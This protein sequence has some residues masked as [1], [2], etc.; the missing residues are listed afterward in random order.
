M[1]LISPE[2][3]ETRGSL[4]HSYLAE[5]GIF[6]ATIETYGI[7]IEA[8]PTSESF[9]DRL[10]FDRLSEGKLAS[11]AKEVI[12]FPCPDIASKTVSWIARPLPSIGD[13]KFLNPKGAAFPFITPET[14]G[15]ASKPHKPII[16]TEGPVKALALVQAGQ[17]AI[18]VSGVWMATRNG[19]DGSVELIAA[20]REF[21]WSGRSVYLAFD[22]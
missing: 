14:W 9:R 2:L 17:L 1:E 10:G 8:G 19:A 16:L 5:R 22:A 21:E 11:L 15:L 12:W 20:L 13:V 7:Q 3:V 6:T 4:A 18:A